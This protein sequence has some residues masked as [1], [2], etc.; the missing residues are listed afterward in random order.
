MKALGGIV[1]WKAAQ[2]NILTM[3][4]SVTPK[5]L[6]ENPTRLGKR[7]FIQIVQ[8][9]TTEWRLQ[10]VSDLLLLAD[11]QVQ[12]QQFSRFKWMQTCV[13]DCN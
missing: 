13:K 8:I 9:L 2:Q 12:E 6:L 5:A 3:R 11:N 7:V 1:W 4:A 10:L